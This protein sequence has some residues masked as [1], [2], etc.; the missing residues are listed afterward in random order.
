M[1]VGKYRKWVGKSLEDNSG[2]ASSRKLLAFIATVMFIVIW[3]AQVY[4]FIKFAIPISN[5]IQY[6]T[7]ILAL[8]SLGL[9]TVQNIIQFA[10]AISQNNYGYP[11]DNTDINIVNAKKS[12]GLIDP[13]NPPMD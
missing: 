2:N 4:M 10:K 3:A 13:N 1:N 12:S 9:V 6:G 5:I 7:I 11:V 8:V